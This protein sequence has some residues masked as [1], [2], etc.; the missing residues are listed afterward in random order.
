MTQHPGLAD[1]GQAL[2][3]VDLDIGQIPPGSSDDMGTDSR[4]AQ[5]VRLVLCSK[6][7]RTFEIQTRRYA[8]LLRGVN[9]ARYGYSVFAIPA[10]GR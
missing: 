3:R 6:F 1:P 7:R 4:D 5:D 9:G 2:V 8:A 10:V